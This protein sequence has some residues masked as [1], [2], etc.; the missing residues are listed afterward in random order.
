MNKKYFLATTLIFGLLCSAACSAIVGAY[1][2]DP[3]GPVVDCDSELPM[4]ELIQ[5]I[6]E[7][8]AAMDK[9]HTDRKI[10]ERRRFQ[11]MNKVNNYHK[12]NMKYKEISNFIKIKKENIYDKTKNSNHP[13]RLRVDEYKN[14]KVAVAQRK[15]ADD[16]KYYIGGALP[17]P[18][19]GMQLN[20][21]DISFSLHH[22]YFRNYWAPS[23]DILVTKDNGKN[24]IFSAGYEVVPLKDNMAL[25]IISI[26]QACQPTYSKEQIEKALKINSLPPQY[27]IF[28][29]GYDE[30]KEALSKKLNNCGLAYIYFT[31]NFD[32]SIGYLEG[33]YIGAEWEPIT[34]LYKE[35]P[36]KVIHLSANKRENPT[37]LYVNLNNRTFEIPL[38]K[39][40][41]IANQ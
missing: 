15:D 11:E 17:K 14:M 33:R 1:S 41:G 34:I 39:E 2:D 32:N 24:K 8:Y 30:T 27:N 37:K 21:K 22:R 26:A 20:M 31:D 10:W 19:M 35:H 9:I 16:I 23:R 5:C 3:Y 6:D 40:G 4:D 28:F 12:V 25:Y 36:N 18:F 38:S 29:R 7:K 13:M